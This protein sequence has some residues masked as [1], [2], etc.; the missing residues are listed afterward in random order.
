VDGLADVHLHLEGCVPAAFLAEIAGRS[1]HRWTQPGRFESDLAGV[2]T[3]AGFLALYAE[4]CRLLK[5]PEDYAAATRAA[6]RSLADG[7]LDYAEIYV[8]PGIWEK[9]GYPVEEIY[10]AVL[11]AAAEMFDA[12]PLEGALLLDV[13]RQFGPRAAGRVLDLAER[14]RNSRVVGL[15]MGGDERAL[16]ARDF[17]GVY[18]RARGL[19]L[20]T[21][22]HAGEWGGSSSV[23][24]ALEALEPDRVDHGIAAS[25]DLTLLRRIAAS[26]VVLSV[27]LSS[28][29]ATGAVGRSASHPLPRLLEAGV[30]VALSADDPVLFATSTAEEY[31]RAGVEFGLSKAVLLEMASNAWRAAFCSEPVRRRGLAVLQSER[32]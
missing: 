7:G 26:G 10:A 2:S 13:V 5:T 25:D 14:H 27:A 15:G 9:L 29:R 28:N 4:I 1:S 23:A 30:A 20:G 12:G 16:P 3:A 11:G 6:L 18:Q 17:A 22:V 21:S 19:G 31:R 24:E 8:S 32:R